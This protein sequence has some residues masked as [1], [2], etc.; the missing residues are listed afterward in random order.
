[1]I[2]ERLSAEGGLL[3]QIETGQWD[4][5]LHHAS[6]ELGPLLG[7]I[8]ERARLDRIIIERLSHGA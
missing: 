6:S 5:R 7:V 1:M 3:H 8:A 4:D 2:L